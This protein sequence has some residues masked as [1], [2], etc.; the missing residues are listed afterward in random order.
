MPAWRYVKGSHF[1]RE[2]QK[3]LEVL[4]FKVIRAAGSGVAG[5]T[6]DLIALGK[7]KRFALE[8][9][10]WKDSVYIPKNRFK[11]ML[12]WEQATNLQTYVAWKAH[13]QQWRFYPLQALRETEKSYAL[14]SGDL[15]AGMTLDQIT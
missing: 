6:P 2:L 9:K 3:R 14:L 7:T 15:E 5:D 11:Q 8:C 10:A 4:G 13:R 12:E 1:E